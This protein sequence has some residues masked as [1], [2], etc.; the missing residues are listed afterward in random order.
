MKKYALRKIRSIG[1]GSIWHH[2][3]ARPAKAVY[4]TLL[5]ALLSLPAVASDYTLVINNG[6][7]MD[8][9]SGLDAI[10]HLGLKGDTIVAVSEQPLEA[11]N[12]IDAGGLVVAPGF[13]DLHT[14]SPTQL[15][16]HYQ[17]FDGVTTALELELGMYPVQHY[18]E[19]VSDS[20]L[21]NYGASAGYLAMRLLLKNGLAMGSPSSTPSP[22]GFRGWWTALKFML[23]DS[24]QALSATVAESVDA[25]ERDQ[26]RRMLEEDLDNGALGIGLAL[27]YI[28]E[29]VDDAELQMIFELAGVRKAPVFIHVRRGINGDPSGLR[30]VLALARANNTPVHICHISHNAMRNIDFFLSEVRQAQQLGVDVTV[31]VLPYN[32]GSTTIGAAVFGRDWQTIFNITYEDVEWA[33]TGERFSQAMWEEYRNKYPSGVVIHHYLKDEWTT[34]ALKEPGSIV[35]SDLIPMN[36]L[37]EKVPPHNGAFS[38]VLGRYVRERGELELM[39]ALEKMTL[40][41]AQRLQ[42][43]APAFARK[44]RIQAAMDADLVLFDPTRII[45]NA[46]YQNP[47]QEASGI[48]YVIVAGELVVRSGEAVAGVTPGRRILATSLP[49]E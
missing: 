31:G 9:E 6:R 45:D 38:K 39:E 49:G 48:E 40:L 24:S 13:I 21:I 23:G 20:A 12:T 11:D 4:Q 8:P 32:A 17:L 29:A 42:A 41:P 19:E 33:A 34:R 28:S 15:G 30:E 3:R 46:T 27:D 5:L 36:T 1:P 26:L 44:G 43:Y 14:H 47:Y 2:C 25:Q 16:Q 18:G 10:R 7:V 37:E 22:Q 35:V